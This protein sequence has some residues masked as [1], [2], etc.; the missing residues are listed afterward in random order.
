MKYLYL[1]LVGLTWS[2]LIAQNEMISGSVTD[3]LG[4][5]LEMATVVALDPEYQAI[6]TYSVTN[7][8]GVFSMLL[9]HGQKYVLKA[10]FLGLRPEEQEIFLEKE[11]GPL[12]VDFV[13]STDEIFLS[14]VEIT[15]EMPVV[16]RGDTLVYNADSF[17]NGTERKLGDLLKKMPGITVNDNGDIEV[18]GKKVS[19][20]MIEGKEF[21]D[22]DS[23]LATQ[24]IPADAVDKV[25]VLKKHH[26]LGQ[27]RNLGY[28]DEAIAVNLKLK[29]GKKDFWFG[30]VEGGLGQGE[31]IRYSVGSKLFYN[32]PESS[33]NI[34]ADVNNIGDVAFTFRDYL[35]F[36]GGTSLGGSITSFNLD[37]DDLSLLT[38]QNDRAYDTR[39]LFGAA[40]MTHHFSSKWHVSGFGLLSSNYTHFRNVNLRRYISSGLLE[41]NEKETDQENK[42][43]MA[44]FKSVYKHSPRFQLDYN[45]LFKNSDQLQT[46][47]AL[48]IVSKMR[49]T[50]LEERK[51]EQLLVRQNLEAYYTLNDD[52]IFAGYLNHQYKK[53]YPLYRAILE[54]QPFLEILPLY[55]DQELFDVN[56][57]KRTRTHSADFK[58][59]YYYILSKTSNLNLRLGTIQNWQT[60]NSAIFQN[61]NSGDKEII[62]DND[63][64]N[65]LSHHL[66]DFFF[67]MRYNV[68]NGMFTIT[69]GIDV[70]RYFFQ[71]Q[72]LGTTE[73]D[74]KTFL[75]PSFRAVAEFRK[76]ESLRLNYNLEAQYTGIEDFAEG[77]VFNDYN[78]LA[79][80]NRNLQ[81]AMHHNLNL[82][83]FNFN[84]YN[85]TNI[86]ATVNYSRR[87]DPI[88]NSTYLEQIYIISSPENIPLFDENFT[89]AASIEKTFKKVKT[90]FSSNVSFNEYNLLINEEFSKSQNLNQNYKGSILTNFKKSPHV[91]VGYSRSIVRFTN[92]EIENSFFTDSP[93]ANIEYALANFN[94][95]A[96][97]AY[98]DF[99]SEAKT[100]ENSYSFV[101]ADIY[102]RKTRSKW[103]FNIK[104]RNLLNVT[105]IDRS[106][107]NVNYNTTSRYLVQ[108]RMI[109]ATVK[110]AL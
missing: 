47:D 109:I 28:E 101:E 7:E 70:H 65:D 26:D 43:W 57:E 83:Y 87:I 40:N 75:S 107:F 60:F 36:M 105:S 93:Y 9:T 48:S 52:N 22:G 23:K 5:P 106:S 27:M 89:T 44:K 72:Q 39:N 2:S 41:E 32:S 50:I 69:P 8:H 49:N 66:S 110:Y 102:Y 34:I 73:S 38:M 42:L 100:L 61:L 58:L 86:F 17:T 14:G 104:G 68:K 46:S 71:N 51:N 59:D 77:Y 63:F 74:V 35:N 64:N 67:G 84:M 19:K 103:E 55:E 62:P 3:S 31:G 85:F 95:K 98:Y 21:F 92:G 81:N 1:L 80:G 37:G 76:T 18:E 54:L 29:E 6:I 97:W 99:S 10:S 20:V 16:K 79:H 90:K 12:I 78:Q 24:N 94:L 11:E 82:S 25:E 15:Y 33:I 108:P 56:Q 53:D 30:E 96:E 91:E 88:N 45:L 4:N 13:L